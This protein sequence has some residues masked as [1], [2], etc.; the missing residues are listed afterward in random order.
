MYAAVHTPFK[1]HNT[2][3]TAVCLD[4]LYTHNCVRERGKR[5]CARVRRPFS[6]LGKLGSAKCRC[7]HKHSDIHTIWCDIGKN[8]HT[9]HTSSVCVRVCRLL[10]V[11]IEKPLGVECT[12]HIDDMVVVVV[13]G[14]G[15]AVAYAMLATRSTPN[16]YTSARNQSMRHETHAPSTEA[17]VFGWNVMEH[18]AFVRSFAVPVYSHTNQPNHTP[19]PSCGAYAPAISSK[20]VRMLTM[21]MR[22]VSNMLADVLW[23]AGYIVALVLR[24]P[25]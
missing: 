5:E 15:P 3:N 17:G 19:S 25:V 13:V 10:C 9:A 14:G 18:T 11:C 2:T 8:T 7:T 6:L 23:L 20:T 4:G 1:Q 12:Q 22:C 24:S 21:M 16:I